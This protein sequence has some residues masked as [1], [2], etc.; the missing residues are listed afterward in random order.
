MKA[1]SIT[2]R[3]LSAVLCAVMLFSCWVF[4]APSASAADGDYYWKFTWMHKD[5]GHGMTNDSKDITIHYITQNGKGNEGTTTMH[6]DGDELDPD[7][8]DTK[9]KTGGPINGFPYK[10]D[11]SAMANNNVSNNAHMHFRFYVSSDNSNWTEVAYSYQDIS[12]RT[13]WFNK[14]YHYA[15]DI[16]VGSDKY[17]TPSAVHTTSSSN[18]FWTGGMTV[19]GDDSTKSITYSPWLVDQY[20]VKWVHGTITHGYY[21]TNYGGTAISG[22]ST[23][24]YGDVKINSNTGVVSSNT[25]GYCA[26]GNRKPEKLKQKCGLK[27]IM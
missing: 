11:M 19:T 1:K 16:T 14:D 27:Q 26:G 15:S 13:G 10:I 23:T 4:T 17:P 8:G 18:W 12:E 21:L 9:E 3:V 7:A 6:F 22:T 20:G 24:A 5:S 25:G 2:K